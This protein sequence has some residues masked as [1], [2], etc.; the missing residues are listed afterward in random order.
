MAIKIEPSL[1]SALA[2]YKTAY[3][4]GGNISPIIKSILLSLGQQTPAKISN[5]DYAIADIAGLSWYKSVPT[6]FQKIFNQKKSERELLLQITGLEYLYIFHRNGRLR[7][8]ALN[9]INGPLPNS[10]LVAAIVWRL[11]DWVP[12]VRLSAANCLQRCFNQTE[13]NIIA[14]YFLT[15]L[16]IQ[17]TW[18]RWAKDEQEC[19]ANQLLRSD[20]VEQLALMLQT[21]Y[22]G[23]LPSTLA[24]LLRNPVIDQYLEALAKNASNSGVRAIALRALIS[25]K[26]HYPNGKK[27]RWVDKTMGLRRYEPN[28]EHRSLTVS[29]DRMDL[30]E[31]AVNDKSA[32]VRR[33]VLSGL[34]KYDLDSQ[35]SRK[36]ALKCISDS[37][38]SVRMRADYI[39]RHTD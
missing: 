11:N 23:P 38:P 6:M 30:Y 28:I 24:N 8:Q 39:I 21:R 2:A 34:I 9:R 22:N 5:L 7:E 16:R 27:W 32:I 10:F 35:I 33:T 37:S 36:L 25:D 17:M 12:Q 19:I 3:E 26:V 15:T 14:E 29:I 20:V 4:A 31:D 13:P 1:H 18:R